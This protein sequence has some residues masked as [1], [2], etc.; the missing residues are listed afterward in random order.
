MTIELANRLIAFRKRFNYSQE[1]LSEKLNV[2]RQSI[3]KWE[4]GESSPSIDYIQQMA[5]LYNVT[6]DDFINV[7]KPVED[8]YK[9]SENGEFVDD[10][11]RVSIGKD[12]IHVKSKNGDR[13]DINNEGVFVGGE[14]GKFFKKHE[15][16]HKFG[17]DTYKDGNTTHVLYKISSNQ[18]VETICGI[19]DGIVFALLLTTYLLLGFLYK[20]INSWMVFWPIL[21]L[22]DTFSSIIR[23]IYYRQFT[24]ISVWGLAISAY[25]LIGMWGSAFGSFNG[26]H[27]RWALLL[28]IPIYYIFASNLDKLIRHVRYSKLKKIYADGTNRTYTFEKNIDDDK[29]DD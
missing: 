28:I 9:K 19:I 25:L 29:F 22:T 10:H 18:T 8:C 26:R 7:E 24:K 17:F 11:D 2:S 4:S 27:P 21:F 16:Q 1:D 5:K 23:A 6:I 14:Q 13:V 15:Y 20:D 12:G 3:S